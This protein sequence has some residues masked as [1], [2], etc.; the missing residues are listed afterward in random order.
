MYVASGLYRGGRMRP[1]RVLNFIAFCFLMNLFTQVF[2]Q[3]PND[4]GVYV[5]GP[6]IEEPMA[7]FQPLPAYTP[8]ARAARV[9]GI[10]FVQV[11]IRKDGTVDSFKVL[12]G[13]GYGLDESVINTISKKWRFRPGTLNGEPVDVQANIAV[14][15]KLFQGPGEVESLVPSAALA[16]APAGQTVDTPAKA[17]PAVIPAD[18]QATKEQ[19]ANLFELM[20]VREQVASLS[21]TLPAL[22]Q[23]QITA[24]MKQMQQNNPA[25]ASPTQEQQQAISKIMNRFMERVLDLYKSDEM[26]AD[27]TEL[28]QKYLTRSDANGIIAFYSSPAGQRLLDIQPVIMPL[29]MLRMQDRVKTSTDEMQ[30]ELMERIQ[31]NAPSADKPTQK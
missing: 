24:R 22:M 28:Y 21:K 2:A 15:F 16:Q 17:V 12:R 11:V 31:P 10:V 9:E 20:R 5:V 30:K 1:S 13:L 18:Q 27:M 3:Q 19:L 14:S 25:L 23:L 26:I 8:E 7:L 29:V 6:G 4:S